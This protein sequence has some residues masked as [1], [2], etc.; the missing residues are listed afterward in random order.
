MTVYDASPVKRKR[1]TQDEMEVRARFLINYAE[2]YAPVSVRGLYYQSEVAELPG[3]TKDESSYAKVQRQVL[4]L[5]RE[6]RLSYR[7]I[8]DATRWMIKPTSYNGL[9]DL[10]RIMAKIYRRSLWAEQNVAVEIWLEKDALAGVINPVTGEYDVP[11]MV[12]RGQASE[13][14]A[15]NSICAYQ[16]L[17]QSLHIYALYDFDQSGHAA[18]NALE[19]KLQRFGAEM[20]VPVIFELLM[21]DDHWV[22]EL[23]LPTRPHKRKT[24]ADRN[25]PFDY[26]CELDAVPPDMLRAVVRAAIED[27]MP[28]DELAAVKRIEELER[29]TILD[30]DFGTAA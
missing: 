27:H 4:K 10:Q 26:A 2:Q 18:A 3:I 6:G 9:S 29:Q 1:A 23:N 24:T 5:R 30:M 25:W 7:Y 28:A 21:L 20:D 12:S 22:R 14:F 16:G 19:E 13:T 8:S 17:G 15:Y 11:L